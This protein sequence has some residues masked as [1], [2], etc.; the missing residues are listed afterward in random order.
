MEWESIQ[1]KLAA[2]FDPMFGAGAPASSEEAESQVLGC[3]LMEQ[4]LI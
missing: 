2:D 3:I 1:G 4:E